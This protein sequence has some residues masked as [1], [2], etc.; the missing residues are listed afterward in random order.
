M[1]YFDHAATGFPKSETVINAVKNSM[2]ICGN[3][4]R[5]SH[6]AAVR[7]AE[8][9]YGCREAVGELVG[10]Q[11]EHI[12]LTP[13]TTFALN[14]AIN[15]LVDG[16]RVIMSPLEHNSVCRPLYALEKQKRIHTDVFDISTEDDGYTVECV[17]K[18][19]KK[20]ISAAVFTHASNVCGRILPAGAIA[21]AVH[22]AG[23]IV[24]LDAA[25]SAGHIDVTF[26]STGADVICLAGHKGLG[27]PLGTGA[28]ALSGRVA[29]RIKPFVYGGSGIASLEREMPKVL[30]ERMEAGTLNAPAFAGLAEAIRSRREG[31]EKKI[32]RYIVSE[33]KKIPGVIM[34]GCPG[35][36][37]ESY[38]P[39]LL[40]NI[41]G[42]GSDAVAGQL[43]S[44]GICVRS[45]WHCSPLAHRFL[46]SEGGV[47]VSIGGSNTLDEARELVRAVASLAE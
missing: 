14:A 41:R 9:V 3:P 4:G 37:T 18:L 27:G 15:G 20:R 25:Q 45:G 33:M 2:E 10:C 21:D 19:C 34:Y 7:A 28:M 47:R 23:G 12:V 26:D 44:K 6:E 17:K 29:R 22:D 16:G 1:I 46:G 42:M 30:P 35:T 32:F 24:I 8:A 40:F 36:D 13:N 38:V 39:V 11:P 43:S 31:S 5:G